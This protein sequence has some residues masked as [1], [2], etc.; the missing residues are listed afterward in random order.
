MTHYESNLERTLST[1]QKMTSNQKYWIFVWDDCETFYESET[2]EFW[3]IR[4]WLSQNHW[5][6]F[7]KK[8]ISR[9][10]S[11]KKSSIASRH[12]T[13]TWSIFFAKSN[14]NAISSTIRDR[15][16]HDQN[17]ENQDQHNYHRF[18]NDQLRKNSF[19]L[20]KKRNCQSDSDHHHLNLSDND[21]HHLNQLDIDHHLQFLNH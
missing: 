20:W 9:S 10:E 13:Q 4:R 15:H 8:S 18:V 7:S 1:E 3:K 2:Y 5:F 21:S 12:S 16:N 14:S 11:K 6:E 17:H 19:N